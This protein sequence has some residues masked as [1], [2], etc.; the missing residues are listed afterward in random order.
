M[1][2]ANT[3]FETK[4]IVCR[5]QKYITQVNNTALKNLRYNRTD[6]YFSE[7]LTGQ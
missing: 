6:G 4:L 7:V 2:T 1:T 5:L 3:F